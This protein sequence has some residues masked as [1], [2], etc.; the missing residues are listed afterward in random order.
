M[1]FLFYHYPSSEYTFLY[2]EKMLFPKDY[3][4]T[5]AVA[6]AMNFHCYCSGWS[7]SKARKQIFNRE[8]MEKE[9]GLLHRSQLA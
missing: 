5:I 2:C 3:P 9:F 8:F 6:L 7:V 4:L 1:D